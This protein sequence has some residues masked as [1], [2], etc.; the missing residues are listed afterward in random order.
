V[1]KAVVDGVL[2]GDVT[3]VASYST[4]FAGVVYPGETLRT[5]VWQEDK[6]L[7]VTTLVDDRAVLTDTVVTLC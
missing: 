5:Q 7:L 1:C 6:R 4:R 3:R 2:D